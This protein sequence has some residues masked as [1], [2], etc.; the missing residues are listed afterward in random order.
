MFPKLYQQYLAYEPK[1]IDSI[2]NVAVE[3][4]ASVDVALLKKALTKLPPISDLKIN[5]QLKEMGCNTQPLI[6]TWTMQFV[7]E[8]FQVE[9]GHLMFKFSKMIKY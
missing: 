2:Y 9:N 5:Q 4:P 8:N 6:P 7:S 3:V 1:N